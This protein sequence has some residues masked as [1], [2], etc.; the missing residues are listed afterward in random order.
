MTAFAG[1]R[2][3]GSVIS[4]DGSEVTVWADQDAVTI[5]GAVTLLGD[6]FVRLSGLLAAAG[7]EAAENAGRSAGYDGGTVR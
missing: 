5:D 3:I 4:L 6:Q 7:W 1:A 2:K